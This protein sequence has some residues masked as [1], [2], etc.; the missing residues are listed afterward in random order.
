MRQN[1]DEIRAY[2]NALEMNCT[3]EQ[4]VVIYKT[5]HPHIFI[6]YLLNMT[7]KYGKS[8]P[9]KDMRKSLYSVTMY[10]QY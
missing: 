6:V 1:D 7:N 4:F 9:L 8:L 5:T 10:V 3:F 2:A